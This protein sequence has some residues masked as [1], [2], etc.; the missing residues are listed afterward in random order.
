ML[1]HQYI[2]EQGTTITH[3]DLQVISA[4]KLAQSQSL[5]LQAKDWALLLGLCP[6]NELPRDNGS[7]VVLMAVLWWER[8]ASIR[9]DLVAAACAAVDARNWHLSSNCVGCA[10]RVTPKQRRSR[11]FLDK[12]LC[13]F[14]SQKWH[15][16]LASVVESQRYYDGIQPS[17]WAFVHAGCPHSLAEIVI[18][19]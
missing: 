14:L 16:A 15:G 5:G 3:I 8:L 4:P 2:R 17:Y 9:G 19:L 13:G 11:A 10:P 18:G 12:K 1:S 7:R 6:C